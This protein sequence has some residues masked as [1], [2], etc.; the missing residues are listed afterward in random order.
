[1]KSNAGSCQNL[2]EKQFVP[3]A[4]DNDPLSRVRSLYLLQD[5]SGR[6]GKLQLTLRTSVMIA[7]LALAACGAQGQA[8]ADAKPPEGEA[9]SDGAVA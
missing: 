9:V 5:G 4:D 7:A 8:T 1:M 3:S 6:M 2:A